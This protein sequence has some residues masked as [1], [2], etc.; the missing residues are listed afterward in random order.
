MSM[1]D[2]TDRRVQMYNKRSARINI[3]LKYT[4]L[5]TC[6]KARFSLHFRKFINR[7]PSFWPQKLYV[8][9]AIIS[10]DIRN[11]I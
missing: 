6:Y 3:L 5:Y 9:F 2:I 8:K 7:I 4:I 10:P 11:E 1:A